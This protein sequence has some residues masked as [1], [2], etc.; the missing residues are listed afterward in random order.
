MLCPVA[1]TITIHKLLTESIAKRELITI[2]T[3]LCQPYFKQ[4]LVLLDFYAHCSCISISFSKYITIFSVSIISGTEE[5]G[6]LFL[7]YYL[8][9]S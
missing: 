2:Y 7:F 1:I 9:P 3:S 5:Y 6:V 8:A 4:C